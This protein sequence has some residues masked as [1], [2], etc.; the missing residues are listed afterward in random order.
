MEFI[1]YYKILG[2]SKSATQEE[3]RKQY[4]KLARKYHPDVNKS[5]DAEQEFK[6][7]GEAYE[8]LKDPEKR[9]LYDQYGTEWKTGRQQEEYRRQYEQQRQ[10]QYQGQTGG[11]GAGG[12]FDFSDT[13]EGAGEYSDFFE[14]LFGGGQR[15]GRTARKAMR[16][17][18][19]DI[20]ASIRIPLEDAFKGSTRRVNFTIQSVSPDGTVKNEPKNL[21]IKIPK[22]VKNGQK[23]RLAGQ[24]S[25][26][27][28][29]G[30][31]GDLYIHVEVETP[32]GYRAEGAD[33]Y[34]DLPVAP[35]E[36]ALGETV[37]VP[38]PDGNLNIKI[39]AGSQQGKKL[40]VKGKGIPARVPGDLYIVVNIALPPAGDEQA[41]KV[42]EE[43]KKLNF[44]P[45]KNFGRT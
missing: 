34:V 4:R 43:M 8:V 12:G 28:N 36:A 30:E 16:Q 11:F 37:H 3:I 41:R 5:P 45:R 9:K 20:R 23:I 6:A 21:N 18:G 17:K 19:E 10:K 42:Y 35:W 40:R 26:G 29:G 38:L 31:P 44:D 15:R 2:V 7:L 25:P 24:G 39:P 22:G 13:F 1:D 32:S 27:Y 14:F 33:V